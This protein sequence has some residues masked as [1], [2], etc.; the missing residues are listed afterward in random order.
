VIPLRTPGEAPG[1]RTSLRWLLAAPHRLFFFLGMTGL[2]A[3]SLWWL[4]HLLGRAAGAPL[5]L[6]VPPSWLH[7]WAMANGFL[8]LYMFGFLFTAGPRWLN[9]NGP[10]ARPLALPGVL[11][12]AAVPLGL[13]GGHFAAG[14][15]A[16]AALLAATAWTMLLARFLRLYRASRMADRVHA[17][18]VLVFFVLGTLAHVAF[19]IG[20]TQLS[21]PG[22]HSAPKT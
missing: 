18:L 3:V 6:A 7:G 11:A 8:P 5:P 10:P 4:A 21:A 13:V 14:L 9:V 16:A 2:A 15:V 12:A 1:A 22:L 17:R 20:I 19:A